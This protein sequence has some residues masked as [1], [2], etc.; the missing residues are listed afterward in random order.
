MPNYSNSRVYKIVSDQTDQIYIG[1]TTQALSRRI[2]EHRSKY[3]RWRNDI[4][5]NYTTS[6]EIVK[7]KDAKIILLERVECKDREELLKVER[8]YIESL[9][10]C[11]KVIPGRT[12][13]EYLQDNKEEIKARKKQYYQDNKEEINERNKQ[14]YQD[15]KENAKQYRQANEMKFKQKF[16]CPCGGRYIY[17]TKSR[18]FKT[19]MHKAYLEQ[20]T[21]EQTSI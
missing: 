3:K 9:N 1:S 4:G 11:N 21:T 6:F 19:N 7:F 13:A 14:Y 18:H 16:N 8:R 17:Q 5:G 20:Q 15:N 12:W 10:C 2:A